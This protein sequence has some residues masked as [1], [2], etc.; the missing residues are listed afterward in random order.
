MR[1]I[2]EGAMRKELES[3]IRHLDLSDRVTLPGWIQPVWEELAAR[4]LCLHCP[5]VMRDFHQ[6]CWKRWLPE[7]PAFPV[8]CQSGPRAV[9]DAN[10]NGL[11]VQNDAASLSI[12]ILRMVQ[13]V[14]LRERFGAAGQGVVDRF[15]WETMVRRNTNKCYAA[16]AN[17]RSNERRQRR[18]QNAAVCPNRRQVTGQNP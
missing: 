7:Y 14:D 9:I 16:Q 6:H 18:L 15:G 17:S 1:I 10:V 2:G 8:D 3:Q 4:N 11:L 12:G 5:V 13:D